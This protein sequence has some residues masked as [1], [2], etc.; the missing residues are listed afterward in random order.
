MY[1]YSHLPSCLVVWPVG[2]VV[3]FAFCGKV[4]SVCGMVC[5]RVLCVLASVRAHI[6][7]STHMLD[8]KQT[9]IQRQWKRVR[10][11]RR[12]SPMTAFLPRLLNNNLLLLFF[13]LVSL[14]LLPHLSSSSFYSSI[15][16]TMFVTNGLAILNFVNFFGLL[17]LCACCCW[18]FSTLILFNGHKNFRGKE[19][20]RNFN[21]GAHSAFNMEHTINEHEMEYIDE[22]T[23]QSQQ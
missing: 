23:K 1:V 19:R 9:T 21:S 4:R 15:R 12:W 10:K 14:S 2:V 5:R 20:S 7:P 3:T 18:R 17:C 11:K 13:F 22:Q 16:A 8:M 6:H